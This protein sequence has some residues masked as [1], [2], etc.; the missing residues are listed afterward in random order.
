MKLIGEVIREVRKSKGMTLEDLAAAADTDSGNISR[1][2]LG[3]QGYTEARLQAIANALGVS[4]AD[5]WVLAALDWDEL[6]VLETY[7]EM[8]KE[9]KEL[10]RKLG[11]SLT[12]NPV[13]DQEDE[14]PL[15][16]SALPPEE[17]T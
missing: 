14:L 9:H 11:K 16:A 13:G 4:V 17:L 3:K 6:E 2:E 12:G 10:Y 5:L 1:L 15:V 7:R 8:V